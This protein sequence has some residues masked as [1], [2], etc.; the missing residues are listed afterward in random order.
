MTDLEEWVNGIVPVCK[1]RH[2]TCEFHTVTWFLAYPPGTPI[3]NADVDLE[4]PDHDE[5]DSSY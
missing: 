1:S 3:H 5:A 2:P 4:G